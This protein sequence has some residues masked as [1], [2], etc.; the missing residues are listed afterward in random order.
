MRSPVCSSKG[1][2]RC[3]APPV[4]WLSLWKEWPVVQA[5]V[6]TALLQARLY[7]FY[8]LVQ[9]H[10][11]SLERLRA[12]VD[13]LCTRLPGARIIRSSGSRDEAADEEAALDLLAAQKLPGARSGAGVLEP[14]DALVKV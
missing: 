11:E 2:E 7:S 13:L 12:A 5:V 3:R 14:G 9:Q 4:L 6:R 1:A 10:V 8:F